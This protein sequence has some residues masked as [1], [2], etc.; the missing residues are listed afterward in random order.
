MSS[1]ETK[2][3]QRLGPIDEITFLP[4][5]FLPSCVLSLKWDLE[6]E[7]TFV[8]LSL[9]LEN[10][11]VVGAVGEGGRYETTILPL[12]ITA[13]DTFLRTTSSTGI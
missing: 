3:P 10:Q 11:G 1:S 2:M 7:C 8:S 4:A 5:W 9:S 6:S 12:R 13:T